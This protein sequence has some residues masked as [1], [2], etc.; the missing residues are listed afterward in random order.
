LPAAGGQA[1]GEAEV[2]IPSEAPAVDLVV[3]ERVG[4]VVNLAKAKAGPGGIEVAATYPAEPGLY[5]L[6]PTLHT[7][8]GVAYDAA[9]QALLTPVL[10]RIGGKIAVA[11]GAPANL[12]LHA[13]MD[14][15]VPVRVLNSGSETWDLSV[16]LGPGEGGSEQASGYHTSRFPA[17]LTA[18]WVSTTAA[19]VPAATSAELDSAIAGPGG[20]VAVSLDVVA[21]DTPGDYLLL[22]DTISPNR[23]PL[24]ALG[25]APALVRVTVTEAPPDPTPIPPQRRG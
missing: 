13:G 9:T 14:A 23:G 19:P 15:K 20:S 10:V 1:D 18:T 7:P 17:V 8:S 21:P 5:R 4:S 22:L 11:Y 25:S 2:V 12:T 3:P 24:S 16:T 6:V